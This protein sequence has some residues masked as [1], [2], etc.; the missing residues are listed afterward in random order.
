MTLFADSTAVDAVASRVREVCEA[1]DHILFAFLF[2]SFAAGRSR[3][4]SDL[5]IAVYFS[6][7]PAGPAV[8]DLANRLSDTAGREVHLAVLNDA[9]ALLRHQ[10]MKSGLR[11]V[12]KDPVLF[13]RFREAV[14]SDYDEYK[15]VSGMVRYDR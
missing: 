12:I 3:E 6:M 4:A 2:G 8:L 13:R 1:D 9:S 11:L 7:P 14:M 15:F 5:D 10:V